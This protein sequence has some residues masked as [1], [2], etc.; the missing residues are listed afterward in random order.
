MMYGWQNK[1]E[2]SWAMPQ[3]SGALDFQW[4]TG[5]AH[6]NGREIS[7][8]GRIIHQQDFG[9]EWRRIRHLL[10]ESVGSTALTTFAQD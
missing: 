7:Q 4:S 1:A 3:L 9:L 8:Q 10:M 2:D 6:P 5:Y